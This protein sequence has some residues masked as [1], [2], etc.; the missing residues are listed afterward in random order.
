MEAIALPTTLPE[1]PWALAGEAI[2]VVG[3]ISLVWLNG[4]T[5][6]GQRKAH[7]ESE[8]SMGD[9]DK[10]MNSVLKELNRANSNVD[11]LRQGLHSN[12]KV[13]VATARS[14]INQIY[15]EHKDAKEI[16]EKTWR[17][18]MELHDAYKSVSID[19]HT[20][21]SWCDAMVDEM[22]KWAKK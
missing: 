17:N 10:K 12:S 4:S 6:R 20:P 18:V 8:R 21:N 13:T 3:V 19:G 1:S 16:D 14:M 15:T 7:K 9:L 2:L 5:H 11:E 22:R